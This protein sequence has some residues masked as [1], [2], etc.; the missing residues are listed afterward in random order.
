MVVPLR[1]VIAASSLHHSLEKWKNIKK[2]LRRE[3]I[4]VPGLSLNP[5]AA[6]PRK[7]VQFLVRKFIFPNNEKFLLWHD[8]VKNS[9]SPHKSYYHCPLSGSELTKQITKLENCQGVVYCPRKGS[10]NIYPLLKKL[11]IPVL[12]V[13][14]ELLSQ[15]KRQDKKFL[16]EYQSLH[17]EPAFEIKML[18]IIRKHS[19]QPRKLIKK[20]NHHLRNGERGRTNK[21]TSESSF[22]SVSMGNCFFLGH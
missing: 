7:T 22:Q 1:L 18:S 21:K 6:N 19:W 13:T 17:Q 10:P 15:R 14:R 4:A 3:V 9:I 8:V 11:K 5:G 2:R 12:R 20:R 16:A